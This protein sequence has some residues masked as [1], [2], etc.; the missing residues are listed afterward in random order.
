LG[1]AVA[2]EAQKNAGRNVAKRATVSL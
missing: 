1:G 2:A